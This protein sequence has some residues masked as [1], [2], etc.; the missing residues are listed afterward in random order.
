MI[1]DVFKVIGEFSEV[2]K[3]NFIIKMHEV[4]RGCCYADTFTGK[5]FPLDFPYLL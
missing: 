2:P 4:G 3:T 5:G 1:N